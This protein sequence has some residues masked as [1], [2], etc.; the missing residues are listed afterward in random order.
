[1][2]SILWAE[3]QKEGKAKRAFKEPYLLLN[4]Y[5][6]SSKN[7]NNKII[8]EKREKKVS[9]KALQP[10]II[11]GF[12]SFNTGSPVSVQVRWNSTQLDKG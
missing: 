6:G 1:M 10:H 9:Q 2:L 7:N 4:F 12:M 5:H 8:K 11:P 3:G